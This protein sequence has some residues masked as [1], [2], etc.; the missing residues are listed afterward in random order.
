[1]TAFVF[2]QNVQSPLAQLESAAIGTTG[3]AWDNADLGKP[4]KLG[5]ANNYIPCAAG[6]EIEGF[7]VSLEAFTVNDGVKFGTVQRNNRFKALVDAAQAT[8]LAAGDLV[9]AGTTAAIGTA[10]AYPKVKAGTPA[11][12]KWRVLNVTSTG[13]AGDTVLLEKI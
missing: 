2:T 5:A 3:Q 6:D 8:P 11:N 12:F 10:D 1:M 4:M 7:L 13:A 9:V